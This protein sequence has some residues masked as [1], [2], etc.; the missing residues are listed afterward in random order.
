VLARSPEIYDWLREKLTVPVVRRYF[1]PILRGGVK[2]YE[3]DNLLGLN[4][5]LEQSLGGGGTVSLILDPQ[6]KTLGQALLEMEVEAPVKIIP[7]D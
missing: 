1:K 4:F 7:T 3:L 2:R 6:G 5:L